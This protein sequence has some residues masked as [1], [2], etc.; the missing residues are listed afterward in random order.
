MKSSTPKRLLALALMLTSCL[1]PAC[2]TYATLDSA[3]KDTSFALAPFLPTE[4]DL[5]TPVYYTPAAPDATDLYT[6]EQQLAL[7]ADRD[8]GGA[9]FLIVQE[10]GLENS[11]FPATDSFSSVY[12][13]RRNRLVQ[14]KYN[15]QLTSITL[16]AEE[17]VAQL[18]EAKRTDVYFC[19]LLVVSPALLRQLQANDLL[20]TLDSLPFFE[21]DSV[22]ISANATAELNSGWTGIYGIWGDLLRQP[23]RQLCVY[24]N[25][26]LAE[27]LVDL[28]AVARAGSWDMD[29]LLTTA[30]L[31]AEL[32]GVGGILYD[33]ST[34]DLLLA[35]SGKTSASAEG[36]AL[37]ADPTFTAQ[38]ERLNALRLPELDASVEG[39]TDAYSRFVAGESLFYI[40]TLGEIDAF[41]ATDEVFGVLPLPKYSA[42][43]PSYPSLT[44]GSSMSVLAC[45]MNVASTAGTG[46]LLSALNA[47]SCDEINDI[48]LQSVEPYLRTNTDYLTLPHLVGTPRFDR[49][50]I[51]E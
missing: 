1:L 46:I 26:S 23:D 37:L 51:F 44:D 39:P 31:T 50:F 38:V 20:V 9:Y 22:C 8:F 3:P 35:L 25:R 29:A 7:L 28:S 32:E 47:A 49:K 34:S 21:T 13:D 2:T 5:T 30:E 15:V 43:D 12:A 11:I 36:T 42:D 16:S 17:I 27:P 18:T 33:G 4:G 24:F 41:S 14:T 6:P 48:F 45:P 10:E 19:D 40:G